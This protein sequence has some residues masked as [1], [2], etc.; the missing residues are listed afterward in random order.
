[1]NYNIFEHT[2]NIG[3]TIREVMTRRVDLFVTIKLL[4]ITQTAHDLN[5]CKI[6]LFAISD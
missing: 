1:M 6:S 4:I 2:V 3:N 5:V